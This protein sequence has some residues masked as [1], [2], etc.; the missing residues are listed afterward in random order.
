MMFNF[1][2]KCKELQNKYGS[3]VNAPKDK[4]NS[5][6]DP[7]SLE[8]APEHWDTNTVYSEVFKEAMQDVLLGNIEDFDRHIEIVKIMEK[9]K[10]YQGDG[11]DYQV[12]YA[13][14]R[15]P[16]GIM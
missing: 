9:V 8:N 1:C 3:L 12:F 14:D 5:V 2:L 4:A 10:Q 16:T 11:Y 7:K 6:F 13:E 15:R